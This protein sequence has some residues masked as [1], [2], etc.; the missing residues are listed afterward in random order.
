MAKA[1]LK[2]QANEASVMDFLEQIEDG[3]KRADCI[4]IARLMQD[5][6]KSLPKMWG[7]SIIGFGEYTYHYDSGRSGD[8]FLMGFSPRKQN[9]TLY[10]MTGYEQHPDIM[11][12][13]GKYKTGKSCLYIN[14]ISDVN[15]DVLHQLLQT[16]MLDLTKMKDQ[17][18]TKGKAK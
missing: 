14:K 7:P 3:Q 9:I 5:I 4:Y 8:W 2:T 1:K 17:F 18:T 12:Q 16:A 15:K 6:T 10:V 11:Q 13:L